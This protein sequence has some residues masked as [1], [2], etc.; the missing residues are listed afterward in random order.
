[1]LSPEVEAQRVAEF[2]KQLYEIENLPPPGPFDDPFFKGIELPVLT[3][4]ADAV[5]EPVVPRDVNTIP[6][7]CQGC[8]HNDTCEFAW[9]LYNTDGDCLALK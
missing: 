4:P 8:P 9:D 5:L 1:M 6:I 2:R 3:M 7:T